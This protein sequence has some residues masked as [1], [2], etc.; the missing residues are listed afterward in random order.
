MCIQNI[1]FVIVIQLPMEH[2]P[3]QNNTTKNV[4]SQK[5]LHIFEYISSNTSAMIDIISI[6]LLVIF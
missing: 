2:I 1:G 3:I 4:D 5:L 6:N